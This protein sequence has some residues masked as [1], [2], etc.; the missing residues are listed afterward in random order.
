MQEIAAEVEL[1]LGRVDLSGM[2]EEEREKEAQ[3]LTEEE[4]GRG[5][6]LS[7]GPLLRAGLL[8]LSEREHVL[9]LT[10]HHVVRDGWS[11]GILIRELGR[12]YAAYRAGEESP[13]AELPIQYADFAQW[14]R[15]WLQG[16]VLEEQLKYWRNT[17][18][19]AP[20]L[21]A[22]PTD[23][24]RPEQQSFTGDAISVTF[25]EQLT[26]GLRAL[27]RRNNTTLYMTLLAGW[28]VLLARLSG[29]ADIVIG[30][31][32]A[33]RTR[34]EIEGLIGFF[35]NTLAMRLDLSG[36]PTVCELLQRVRAQALAAQEHQDLPFEQI[37]EDL[38]PVRDLSHSPVV[39]AMFVWEYAAEARLTL[40]GLD[41]EAFDAMTYS[42]KFDITLTLREAANLISGCVAYPPALF[43]ASTIRRHI[44]YFHAILREMAENDSQIIDRLPMLGP[45]EQDLVLYEWNQTA[46]TYP[47]QSPIHELFRQ[48]AEN[49]PEAIAVISEQETLSYAELNA[50]ANRLAHHLLALG[51][52]VDMPVAICL[53]SG[54]EMVVAMLGV[55]K[56]G[57]AYV[58]FDPIYPEERLR[59]MMEDA[60]PA[61][62][63]TLQSLA[64]KFRLGEPQV[65]C[66]D[67]EARKIMQRP[68]TSPS[69]SVQMENLAYVIYTS[70]TTG[71]PK[72]VMIRHAGIANNIRDLNQRLS[73]DQRD[74]VISLSP[75]SFDMSVYETLGILSAGGT[76]II[77][78]RDGKR[79][80]GHWVDLIRQHR[81]SIWNSVPAMLELLMDYVL[82]VSDSALPDLRLAILGGDKVPGNLPKRLAQIAP[83]IKLA[84]LG[85]ATE[86]SIHSTVF[87][88]ESTDSECKTVPY[89]RP[90]ANQGAYVLDAQLNPAPVGV[91]GE[92]YLTGI[93]LARGYRGQPALTAHRFIANPYGPPG[94]RMYRTGDLVRWRADGNLEILGRADQQVKVRGFRIELSEIETRLAEHPHVRE[95]LVV[96]REDEMNQKRLVAYYTQPAADEQIVDPVELRKHL[97]AKLPEYMVPSAYV[98]LPSLPLT[99]NGKLDRTRL[100]VP[101]LYAYPA[102]QYE[103]PQGD[104]ETR[105]ASIWAAILKLEMV[106]RNDNFFELGGHSLL[107]SLVVS[108]IRNQFQLEVP[109]RTIF[110]APTVRAVAERVDQIA[111]C[112]RLSPSRQIELTLLLNNDLT[113]LIGRIDELEEQDIDFLINRALELKQSG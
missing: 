86:L 36:S 97:S 58:P 10:M 74:R 43:E 112:S 53:E 95:A 12:L 79:D 102:R 70:G 101:D 60:R 76:V 98:Q 32:I 65:V 73:V 9:L 56:A 108:R 81:V 35:V 94:A 47:N 2:E 42:A 104:T 34:S 8:R 96:A 3:R 90:M 105:I 55:L 113:G 69:M 78:N 106:G 25:D 40:P 75:F 50:R 49:S 93:G 66:L 51:V 80:P 48:H 11:V 62:I 59:L 46:A 19:G 77:P 24:P 41:V 109:L 30:S 31:P 111:Q 87:V 110:D 88:F 26:A 15:E 44:G 63:L 45:A 13:L 29:E 7:R 21:L 4:A 64:S 84:V 72:G 54:I 61:L 18:F 33:N 14:Q 91:I 83:Q 5:F 38:Q 6:D 92:L 23:H 37:V 20:T 103:A 99:V 22:L 57:G 107:A 52:T 27:S 68:A 17:L 67:A 82:I 71:R 39:Q 85:G 28:A 16:E 1:H 89:G 100:P